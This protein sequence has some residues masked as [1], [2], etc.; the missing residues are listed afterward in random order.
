LE[1][2][3]KEKREEKQEHDRLARLVEQ[4]AG[5]Q[6]SSPMAGIHAQLTNARI[7]AQAPV[8]LHWLQAAAGANPFQAQR[9]RG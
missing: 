8:P 6:V 5:L 3:M 4:W 7:G 2:E 1:Q 9:R